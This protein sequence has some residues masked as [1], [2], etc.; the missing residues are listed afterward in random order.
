M[1]AH[2]KLYHSRFT[3]T[4]RADNSDFLA[5]FHIG[6]EI[7]DD[8]LVGVFVAEANVVKADVAA[9]IAAFHGVFRRFFDDL[10]FIKEIENALCRRHGALYLARNAC[11]LGDGLRETAQ[12]LDERLN[13]AD[14]HAAACRHRCAQNAHHNVAEI[15]HKAHDR[16]HQAGEELRLPARVIELFVFALE[17]LHGARF[18]VKCLHDDVPAVH[19]LHV[20]V[21]RA[22][23]FLLADEIFLRGFHNASD[24]QQRNRDDAQCDKR[25]LPADGKHHNKHADDGAHRRDKLRDTLVKTLAERINIVRDAGKHVTLT[26]FVKIRD[27]QAVD[28][29]HNGTAHVV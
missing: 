23:V 26:R 28:L 21:H 6:G 22:E 14:G 29:F 20:A 10:G 25:Q 24:K 18:A 9:D 27:G 5:C 11:H 1:E 15:A 16:L 4:R 12:I 2:E 13:A 3:C 17:F 7:V 19:F 8:S